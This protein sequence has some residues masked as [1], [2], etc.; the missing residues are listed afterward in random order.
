[1]DPEF[2]SARHK[3]LIYAVEKLRKTVVNEKFDPYFNILKCAAKL[4]LDFASILKKKERSHELTLKKTW[5]CLADRN[6]CAPTTI[7]WSWTKFLRRL[8]SLSCVVERGS[9]QSWV[10]KS[11]QN[12]FFAASLKDVP[13]GCKHAVLSEPLRKNCTNNCLTYEEIRR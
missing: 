9:T 1:M 3:V 11:W 8:T 5:I 12:Y 2:E 7:W 10:S 4:N 13:M 6:S